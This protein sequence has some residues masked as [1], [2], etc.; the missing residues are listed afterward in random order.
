[1]K[2]SIYATI[3]FILAVLFIILGFITLSWITIIMIVISV[4]VTGY[5]LTKPQREHIYDAEGQYAPFDY[6]ANTTGGF[7]G[8]CESALPNPAA[9]FCG[10]CGVK[11]S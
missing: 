2:D 7:C 6:S 10:N 9:K 8:N 11:V 3:W 4:T 5:Y 1:M